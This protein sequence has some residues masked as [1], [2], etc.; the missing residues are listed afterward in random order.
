MTTQGNPYSPVVQSNFYVLFDA[1]TGTAKVPTVFSVRSQSMHKTMK[2]PI[3]NAYSMSYM[4]E[5]EPAANACTEIFERKLQE[6]QGAPID[7]GTWLHWYAFDLI[8]SITFSNRLGFMEKETDVDDIIDSLEGRLAYNSVVGQAPWLHNF[9]L[10]NRLFK[11]IGTRFK[12]VAKLNTA[13]HIVNFAAEQ[14]LRYNNSEKPKEIRD[15]LSRFKTM[16]DGESLISDNQLLAHAAS[17]MCVKTDPSDFPSLV[18]LT[19]LTNS[20]GVTLLPSLCARSSITFA[21]TLLATRRSS[22]RS[23]AWIAGANCLT[24]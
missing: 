22:Q 16:Q 9:L 11:S 1:D 2:R 15:M 7:L 12:A 20:L 3:A 8:T 21:G 4:I 13:Q 6:N 24:Q 19:S 18:F 23:M 10:G 14:L 5:L 17:N